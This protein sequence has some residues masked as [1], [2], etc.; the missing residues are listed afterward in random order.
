[1]QG[2]RRN[3][4][5]SSPVV[6]PTLE[7]KDLVAYGVGLILIVIAILTS[8]FLMERSLRWQSQVAETVDLA[9]SQRMLSQRGVQLAYRYLNSDDPKQQAALQQKLTGTAKR[10]RHVHLQLT[11]SEKQRAF[12]RVND[13]LYF[14]DP[15][16]LDYQIQSFI[17]IFE[18]LS[19]IHP[20]YLHS[21]SKMMRHLNSGT[22]ENLLQA[23]EISV[24]QYVDYS[25]QQLRGLQRQLLLLNLFLVIVVLAVGLLLFL[26]LIKRLAQRTQMYR[27]LSSVDPLTGC[28][29][30]RSFSALAEAHH[31]GLKQRPKQAAAIMM[32][33]IDRF[34]SV[35]D[36][37]GH[38][39]GD[40]VIKA[41]ASITLQSLRK[42]DFLGRLGGEEFAV[43]LPGCSLNEA[44]QV[45]EKL[46]ITLASSA[47]DAGLDHPIHFTVSIGVAQLAAEDESF[48]AALN[49][50][51]TALY[52][53]K[54]NG[55]NRVTVFEHLDPN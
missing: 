43:V 33:D 2:L 35:N 7:R 55:R 13:A 27:E 4:P 47:V 1:M 39:I 30:R 19:R 14:D 51:D 20:E 3:Q 54:Q 28:H 46:R 34:K 53:A 49:R 38:A 50:A 32:L 40:L 29:N 16:Q 21:R 6:A 9:G 11:R 10:F 12:A 17:G 36:T 8:H 15:H 31:Q 23:L 5:P 26:P 52:S 25:Q 42:N 44:E 48:H 37:Y 41:L 45:A 24:Q 18:N 22:S